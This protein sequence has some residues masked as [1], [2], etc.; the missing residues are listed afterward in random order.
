MRCLLPF[1]LFSVFLGCACR[2]SAQ[3]ISSIDDSLRIQGDLGLRNVLYTMIGTE[4]RRVPY[5]YVLGANLSISKG[6]FSLPFGFTYS[7]QER[8]FTQPFNQFGLTPEYKWLK[9]YLGYSSMNWSNYALGGAQFSGVGLELSPKKWRLGGMYGRF[10]R[11]TPVDSIGFLR[12]P[13][14]LPSYE[15]R[16]WA[17]K[18]GRGE[19]DRFF[20]FIFFKGAD[21]DGGRSPILKDSLTLVFPAEN[22][23][24]AIKTMV[25]ISKK[26]NFRFDGG[27]SLFTRDITSPQLEESEQTLRHTFKFI[28]PLTASTNIMYGGDATLAFNHKGHALQVNSKYVLPDYQTMGI[29][30]MDNDVFSYGFTHAF[31]FLKS[32]VQVNYGLNRLN[33]NLLNKKMLTTIRLQPLVSLSVNPSSK[34]GFNLNWNNF[35]T[36]QE[37]GRISLSDSFRMNQTNPGI[38]ITPYANWGDTSVYH[39]LMWVY[40]RIQLQDLNAYTAAYSQYTATVYS[41]N[42]T[43]NLPSRNSSYNGGINYTLNENSLIREEGI[44]L[45]GGLSRST[46][47]Q[48]RTLTAGVQVQFSNLAQQ[49][50]LQAGGRQQL[51]YRQSL[52][53]NLGILRNQSKD[54]QFRSF[55]EITFMVTYSKSFQYAFKKK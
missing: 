22:T 27:I 26:I 47:D 13:G 3:D 6:D 29:Y 52:D 1:L 48:K 30:F 46:R 25:P 55:T 39:S 32:K 23:A 24:V 33:D 35:Y 43:R 19:D 51:K 49:Y 44:G 20:D 8:N 41:M 5:S 4:K 38:T 9:S 10:R 14:A 31:S 40:T 53:V 11:A 36:R 45:S 50:R 16:G 28:H 21:R 54:A 42:Y 7:E 15:R 2:L 34:W 17:F 37:D 18:I 12:D